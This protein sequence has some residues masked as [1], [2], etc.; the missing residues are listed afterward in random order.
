MSNPPP[1]SQ[2]ASS[3]DSGGAMMGF[4]MGLIVVL[5]ALPAAI[6]AL[7]GRRYMKTHQPMVA[8]A[9]LAGAGFMALVVWSP[10]RDH[11]KRAAQQLSGA[12]GAM[13]S[14]AW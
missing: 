2:S 10:L 7:W 1:A 14:W 9:A 8:M 3:G 13:G 4:F 12:S 11:L 6:G 5:V